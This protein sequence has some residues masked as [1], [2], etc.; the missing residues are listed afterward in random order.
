MQNLIKKF[1]NLTNFLIKTHFIFFCAVEENNEDSGDDDDAMVEILECLL[2]VDHDDVELA[3]QVKVQM[4]V[5]VVEMV[6]NL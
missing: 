2:L 1:I 5:E 3:R 4:V 6:W